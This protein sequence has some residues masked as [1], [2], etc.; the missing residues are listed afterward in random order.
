MTDVLSELSRRARLAETD[1]ELGFSLVNDSMALAPFRQAALWLADGGAWCL[2]GVVQVDANVPYV[3]WLNAVACHM[4]AQP[5]QPVRTFT[6]QDL[7]AELAAD[8]NDWWPEHAVWL[9]STAKSVQGAGIFVRDA[10]WQA[11][12]LAALQAWSEVWWHAFTALHRPRMARLKSWR[13]R[14]GVWLGWQP[15]MASWRQRRLLVL[16]LLLAV[17]CCPVRLTVLAPGELVPAK[18]LVIRAPLDGVIDVFHVQ[19]NQQIQAGQPLFSFDEIV[20][21]SRLDVAAQALVTAETDYRQTSQMALMEAKS[22]VQLG[23]LVGKI[24]ERKAEIE[25]L[26]EQLLRARVSAPIAGVVLMDDPAEWIGKPVSTGER[27][28]RI[29]TLDDVEVEAWLPMADAIKLSVGDEVSLY[30]S[31]NPLSPVHATLRYMAYEAVQRPDGVYAYRVR[32]TLSGTS[33]HRIGLKGTAKLHGGWV[34][35]VY[36]VLRRPWATLRGYVGL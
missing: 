15:G 33:Q 28:L 20:I 8:W 9:S 19:P 21:Q 13:I 23:L 11:D 34:P 4:Q 17:I 22:K 10:S 2:S 25:Y 31:A 6:A 7:P 3:Q 32:A 30:L 27:I 12:E 26:K 24:E 14:L 16:M 29:A 5:Q 36:W 18:P 1:R 35:L